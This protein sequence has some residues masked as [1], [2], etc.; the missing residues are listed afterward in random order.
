ML[1]VVAMEYMAISG[2]HAWTYGRVVELVLV[3][4]LLIAT[5]YGTTA[6]M[7]WLVTA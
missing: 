4:G 5:W 3:Y 7:A 2:D 1:L 6:T